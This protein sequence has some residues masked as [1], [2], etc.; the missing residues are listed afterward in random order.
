MLYSL[1][2]K[3]QLSTSLAKWSLQS[4]QSVVV[5]MGLE[6]CQQQ[7]DWTESELAEHIGKVCKKAKM[8]DIPILEIQSHDLNGGLMRLGQ[9]VSVETQLIFIGKVSVLMKQIVQH[10]MSM[11][12]KVCVVHDAILCEHQ[13]QHIQCID[14]LVRQSVHHMNT[15][16][17]LRLWTLSAPK[18]QILSPKGVLLAVAE[19]LD[20]EPLEI[21]PTVDLRRY[22]LDSVAMVQLIALWRAN[23]AQIRYEQ[24]LQ[25][26]SVN[27]I[28]S[29]LQPNIENERYL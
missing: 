24:F 19:Q 18:E 17:L 25:H 3:A 12:G 4:A 23:G 16:S 13:A 27:E 29:L 9:L 15:Y 5:L 6:E 20:L 11:T 7:Q 21:D 14:A 28:M 10:A 2:H 26:A 1:P 8:L 22:G